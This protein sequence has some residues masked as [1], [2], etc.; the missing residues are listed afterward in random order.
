MLAVTGAAQPVAMLAWD[1]ATGLNACWGC[2]TGRSAC[3]GLRNRSQCLLGAAQPVAML[4]GGCI[5]GR[6]ACCDGSC[7]AGHNCCWGLRNRSQCLL[8]IAQPVSMLA[9]GCA[10]GRNA[11]W[12]L[13]RQLFTPNFVDDSL[14]RC[15]PYCI[16]HNVTGRAGM[17]HPAR[18]SADSRHVGRPPAELRSASP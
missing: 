3:C 12:G 2:A 14:R 4:A 18:W 1:C 6:N 16:R 13:C 7:A 11:C 10:A 15:R 8:G 5:A 9:G 17:E